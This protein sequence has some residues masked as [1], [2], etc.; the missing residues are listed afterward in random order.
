MLDN[1]YIDEM[2]T[3]F[4]KVTNWLSS[5]GDFINKD[6]EGHWSSPQSLKIEGYNIKGALW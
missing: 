1:D 5:L 4:A 3:R 2:L 6:K